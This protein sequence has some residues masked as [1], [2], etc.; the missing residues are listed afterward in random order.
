LLLSK[1][2]GERVSAFT[3]VILLGD[4]GR[5]AVFLGGTVGWAPSELWVL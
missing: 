5:L 2:G 3:L 4:H 1:P